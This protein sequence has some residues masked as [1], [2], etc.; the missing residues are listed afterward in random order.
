MTT[1]RELLAAHVADA[2]CAMCHLHFDSLG[3]AMEGFD[4]IGRVRTADRAGRPINNEVELPN[5]KTATGIS[6]LIEYIMQHRREDFLRTLCRRFLGYA[7]GR[8]VNLSDQPL[9]MAMEEALQ[10]NEFRFSVMFELVVRSPQF[11]KQ[12]GRGFQTTTR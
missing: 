12:R 4:P 1:I 7:L 5:G 2:Q 8:S 6:G 3:L 11:R 9:L 10:E